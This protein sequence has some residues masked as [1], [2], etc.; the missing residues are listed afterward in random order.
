MLKHMKQIVYSI[1]EKFE[2]FFSMLQGKGWGSH[3]IKSEVNSV[4]KLLNNPKLLIDVG[5]N[6]GLYTDELIALYPNSEIHLFE[7]STFNFNLLKD[8]F[9]NRSN[10]YLNKLALSNFQGNVKLYAPEPGSGMG[11]LVQ[12]NL[13]HFNIQSN[14]Q[15]DVGVDIF[16]NYWNKTLHCGKIDFLKIDVEGFELDVLKGLGDSINFIKIIQFEFGGCNLDT[17]TSFQDFFYFFK[18]KDFSV[19]R[20]TPFGLQDISNYKEID[21][22][23]RT[24]NFIAIKN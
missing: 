19:K 23:Y 22:C 10:I 20:I 8:K 13:E 1:F 4:S 6:K 17:K 7:P 16:E 15:E 14:S 12:R 24:T 2:L 21:E 3:T 18:N 5:A 9:S 11:S